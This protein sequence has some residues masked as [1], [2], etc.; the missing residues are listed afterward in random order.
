MRRTKGS[1]CKRTRQ[2]LREAKNELRWAREAYSRN[3]SSEA[4]YD[5]M[6]AQRDEWR[7]IEA[8]GA[9]RAR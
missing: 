8:H 2:A 4:R 9:C 6:R 1:R 5:I 7:A 3:P